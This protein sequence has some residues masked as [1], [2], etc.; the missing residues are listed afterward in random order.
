MCRT[1][2]TDAREE[3]EHFRVVFSRDSKLQCSIRPKRRPSP[4][5]YTK[6]I[7]VT[8]ERGSVIRGNVWPRV[9]Y[10]RD[11]PLVSVRRGG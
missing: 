4:V 3:R 11:E 1:Q 5:E 2:R 7:E 10:G 9:S 8:D 6:S